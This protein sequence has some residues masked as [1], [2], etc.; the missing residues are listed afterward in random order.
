MAKAE[1]YQFEIDAVKATTPKGRVKWPKLNEP[2]T[3]FDEKK[4]MYGTKFL[5]SPEDAKPLIAEIDRL[6][7]AAVAEVKKAKK[8]K[9]V[10]IADPMYTN[11][12]DKEGEETGMIEFNFRRRAGGERKDGT[13]WS[14][15]LPK[16]DA[17][18]KATT[19]RITG[20]SLCKISLELTPF[21]VPATG[22]GVSGK[23]VGVQVLEVATFEKSADELGF[24]VEDDF[25]G[26]DDEES[27]EDEDDED[28]DEGDEESE[29][30][31]DED[32]IPF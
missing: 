4:P 27:D 14:I 31:E 5:L 8:G 26:Q 30:D 2:D 18:A 21:Y 11:E 12:V 6:T 17:K 19:V 29:E 28:E 13:M 25:D 23:I 10:K 22:V 16:F 24:E 3:H 15:E 32:S 9:K 20:G 7:K 1:F